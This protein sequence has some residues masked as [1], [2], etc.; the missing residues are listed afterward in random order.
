MCEKEKPLPLLDAGN[1]LS[2]ELVQYL[3]TLA[4]LKRKGAAPTGST[5]IG[6]GEGDV[7]VYGLHGPHADGWIVDSF[8]FGAGGRF[9]GP[10]LMTVSNE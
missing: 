2:T 5:A 10:C 7:L 6:N 4:F 1:R 3:H 8:A 9:S